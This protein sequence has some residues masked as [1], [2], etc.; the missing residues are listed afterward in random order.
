VE[1]R[2]NIQK[3]AVHIQKKHPYLYVLN[4]EYVSNDAIAKIR[5]PKVKGVRILMV[6]SKIDSRFEHL[7]LVQ[8]L[9]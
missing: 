1:T 7:G 8:T 5:K 9:P 2:T 4:I 6:W 3:C